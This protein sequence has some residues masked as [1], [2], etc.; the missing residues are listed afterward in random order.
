MGKYLILWVL[1]KIKPLYLCG[2]MGNNT[3][4]YTAEQ[5]QY[6]GISHM[7]N[8]AIKFINVCMHITYGYSLKKLTCCTV[9]NR[10]IFI[11]LNTYC[12]HTIAIYTVRFFIANIFTYANYYYYYYNNTVKR[13]NAIFWKYYII[14]MKYNYLYS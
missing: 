13:K 2:I 7:V 4:L 12:K 14:M 11:F 10:L 5:R 3:C 8:K 9:V 1:K 6:S